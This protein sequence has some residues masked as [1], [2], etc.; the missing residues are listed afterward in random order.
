MWFFRFWKSDPDV[1]ADVL[2]CPLSTYRRLPLKSLRIYV[3]T[4]GRIYLD[5][6]RDTKT[7]FHEAP[8]H[9]ITLHMPSL[10]KTARGRAVEETV[11]DIAAAVATKRV[12]VSRGVGWL[13]IEMGLRLKPCSKLRFDGNGDPHLSSRCVLTALKAKPKLI[14][15]LLP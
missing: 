4:S 10:Y 7:F 2:V 6:M 12:S 8:H 9:V 11:A 1:F 15:N 14:L 5:N 13:L 3:P